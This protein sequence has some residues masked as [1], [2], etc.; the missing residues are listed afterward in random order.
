VHVTDGWLSVEQEFAQIRSQ[1]DRI[2]RAVTIDRAVTASPVTHRGTNELH[3]N[4]MSPWSGPRAGSISTT[5]PGMSARD[6]PFMQVKNSSFSKMA[7]LGA[8]FGNRILRLER[9]EPLSATLSASLFVLQHHKVMAAL[10]SF[11]E[12]VHPWYPILEKD[13][14]SCISSCL[15]N[16]FKRGTDSFL[17][18]MVLA[19]GSIAQDPNL[20]QALQDRPDAMYL[21]AALDMMHLVILEH[22]LRSV[23]C[24]AATSI[25]YYLLLKPIQAHDL[26]VMAIKKLQDLHL[27]GAF[28]D[29]QSN[30]EH[31]IRVYRAVLLVEGELAI[32]L[33]LSDINCWENEEEIPLPT[34]TDIWS[35]HIDEP[36]YPETPGAINNT[37]SDRLVT[38]LLAEVAMRRMLQRNTTSVSCTVDG[39]VEYAPVIAREL[40]AQLEQWYSFLPETLRF[41]R[42]FGNM[43]SVAS[44]QTI[45]LCTQYWACMVSISW[46]SV[47]KVMESHRLSQTTLH[48]CNNYFHAFWQ[49]IKSGTAALKSCLPNKWTIYARC[50]EVSLR[51]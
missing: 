40:E 37:H 39:N 32:P 48:E 18:L 8:D 17:V 50:V 2:E 1:L 19:S 35:F 4:G 15:A 49:F 21:N 13:F 14:S 41:A 34:G 5:S 7:G 43:Q 27:S 30:F 12:T 46:P 51:Q 11:S 6:F 3:D 26:A 16:S 25:H 36:I 24:L 33:R 45:F 23:Q 31:W 44:P 42:D 9:S 20:H 28:N 10:Q 22:S 29:D 38:Y 47:V